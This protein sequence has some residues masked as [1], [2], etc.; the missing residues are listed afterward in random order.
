MTQHQQPHNITKEELDKINKALDSKNVSKLT[1]IFQNACENGRTEIVDKLIHD[2]RVDNDTFKAM[3]AADN[4]AGFRYACQYDRTETVVTIIETAG[5]HCPS[6]DL[7]DMWN[8]LDEK[9]KDKEEYKLAMGNAL[10]QALQRESVEKIHPHVKQA[11]QE[12]E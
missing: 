12:R 1:E 3:L 7:K 4:Y 9:Y 11:N 10:L 2:K 8:S 6:K 5:K